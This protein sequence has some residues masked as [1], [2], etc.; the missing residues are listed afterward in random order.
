MAKV[1]GDKSR[2]ER[3]SAL[4]DFAAGR[5][6]VVVGTDALIGGDDA[7]EVIAMPYFMSSIAPPFFHTDPHCP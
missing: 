7:P 4:G 6:D 5:I 3:E 2:R 1:H